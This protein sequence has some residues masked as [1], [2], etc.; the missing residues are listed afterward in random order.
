MRN[1]VEFGEGPAL[2]GGLC[3]NRLLQ[4][5]DRCH[6]HPRGAQAFD[7]HRH[8]LARKC[9]GDHRRQF[10]VVA[11][12]V[13]DCPK[14]R[15][16]D[17]SGDP[18][19]LRNPFP[20]PLVRRGDHQVAVAGGIDLVR[21]GDRVARTRTLGAF[22]GDP[23]RGGLVSDEAEAGIDQRGLHRPHRLAALLRQ[24]CRQYAHGDPLAG[25]QIDDRRCTPYGR[26]TIVPV[27]PHDPGERLD[28]RIIA[29]Q[30]APDRTRTERIERVVE[31]VGADRAHRV[32]ADADPLRDPR[33]HTLQQDVRLRRE[34]QR[35]IASS[36][37]AKIEHDAA[38]SR[39]HVPV[40]DARSFDFG[41][42]GSCVVARRGLHLDHV[43]AEL[44][45]DHRGIRSGHVGREVQDP[46]TFERSERGAA[47]R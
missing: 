10:G 4:P 2:G 27:H 45:K 29:G 14:A 30:G 7:P 41:R 24:H 3:P 33:P 13:G 28:Q 35:R 36:S 43:G 42:P 23:R 32:L 40:D 17:Q 11:A 15:V 18:Q 20:Q 37:S 31:N 34:C 1:A 38:L 26:R 44:G 47:N 16:I 22:A 25:A 19:N 5:G 8:V 21:R 46:H 6:R 12:A 39:V 9:S